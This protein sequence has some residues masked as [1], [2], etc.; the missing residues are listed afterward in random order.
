M[1]EDKGQEYFSDG[2]TE[3]IISALSRVPKL[4][5]IARNSTFTYK[6]RPVKVQQVSEELGV[7]Y[8][9]E[10]SV[11]KAGDR[12][13]ITAQLI[14]ATTGHHLWSERYDRD[15]KDIFAL[16]DEITMKIMTGLQVKLTEGEQARVYGKGT[17]N[18]EAYEKWLQ[19]REHLYRHTKED[20]A[21]ARQM[22][23]EA[24]AL[25]PEYSEAYSRLGN[26]HLLDVWYGWSKSPGKSMAQAFK[27]LQKALALDESSAPAHSVLGTLYLLRRQHEKAITEGE[28][29]VALNP[30][31]TDN[32]GALAMTLNF[33]GRQEEAIA[34]FKKAIRLNPMP[35][36]WYLHHLGFAYFL[37]GHYEETMA[38]SK[39]IL[40][41]NP[42]YISAYLGLACCNAVL[43]REEEARAAA[44]EVLRINPK[45][46]LKYWEKALPF[47]KQADKV[48]FFDALRKAGLK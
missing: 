6:G 23:E 1:S 28:R 24:I 43:G 31:A 48:L 29:A 39:R 42:D 16:Q 34:L 35:P 15:L 20:N 7:R 46:S 10:G 8:V 37:T 12:V 44:A 3:E 47:K 40:N 4:F 13:R 30:N 2:L 32:M 45:T 5:V 41:R 19:G 33:A 18:L 26:S 36:D 22:F 17:D 38:L 9:L 27:L 25:D 11:R 14:D 21:L